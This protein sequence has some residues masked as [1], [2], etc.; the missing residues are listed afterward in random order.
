MRRFFAAAPVLR[1][2]A[3]PV[4]P[5]SLEVPHAEVVRMAGHSSRLKVTCRS[6]HLHACWSCDCGSTGIVSPYV[7][8]EAAIE[9]AHAAVGRHHLDR[10][11]ESVRKA[12]VA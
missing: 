2:A 6:G 9:A 11:S 12:S 5:A 10:H 8:V 3:N 1:P 7:S 4:R